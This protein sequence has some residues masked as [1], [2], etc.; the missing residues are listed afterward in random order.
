MAT[1]IVAGVRPGLLAIGILIVVFAWLCY[2]LL[3]VNYA[4]Y[5]VCVTSYFVFLLGFGGLPE[6]AVVKYR[7]INTTLGGLFA[8][9]A[10][11]L[12]PVTR[13]GRKVS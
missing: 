7:S 4:I 6:I 3:H 11:G 2:S 12:W 10:Y 5:V 1:L 13:V 8:L 9:L